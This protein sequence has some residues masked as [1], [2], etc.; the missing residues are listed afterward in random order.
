MLVAIDPNTGN[1]VD[2]KVVAQHEA[3]KLALLN[4]QLAGHPSAAYQQEAIARMQL[5]KA[6]QQR[7]EQERALREMADAN[8]QA[9]IGASQV[10]NGY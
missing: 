10:P 5:E 9:M 7:M 3:R 8:V 1:P 2:P 6:R 4:S